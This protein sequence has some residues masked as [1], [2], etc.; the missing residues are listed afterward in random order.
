MASTNYFN[1]KWTGLRR[2]KNVVMLLEWIPSVI[3]VKP[4]LRSAQDNHSFIAKIRESMSA[5]AG[6]ETIDPALMKAY[7]LLSFHGS[8]DGLTVADVR[9]TI[10]MA[11]FTAASQDEVQTILQSLRPEGEVTKSKDAPVDFAMFSALLRS[12][13]IFRH[14]TNRYWVAVSLA[15]AETLRRLIHVK[16]SAGAPLI[17]GSDTAIALRYSP[18]ASLNS[19]STDGDTQS[20]SQA[21]K[22]ANKVLDTFC[23]IVFD[24]TPGWHTQFGNEVC[25]SRYVCF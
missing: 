12:G 15:E 18:A 21:Q 20:Q 13:Q 25:V 19:N 16:H 6:E 17:K 9:N 5:G 2:L 7:Q 1:R 4:D 14:H 10:E 11:A 8:S 23:G 22:R 24:G 3:D